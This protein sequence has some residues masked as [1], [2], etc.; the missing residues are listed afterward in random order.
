MLEVPST[1]THHRHPIVIMSCFQDS[2]AQDAEWSVALLEEGDVDRPE[3]PYLTGFLD[4]LEAANAAPALGNPFGIRP[5]TPPNANLAAPSQTSFSA[6]SFVPPQAHT[7]SSSPYHAVYEHNW[8]ASESIAPGLAHHIWDVNQE[9]EYEHAYPTEDAAASSTSQS[10]VLLTQQQPQRDSL[11]VQLRSAK[12]QDMPAPLLADLREV[13]SQ[14]SSPASK[15]VSF[16]P[17]FA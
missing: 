16:L 1:P 3:D 4:G 17:P 11:R 12:S 15:S 7:H 6:L 14:H 8:P 2:S 13:C 9:D 5:P 10:L